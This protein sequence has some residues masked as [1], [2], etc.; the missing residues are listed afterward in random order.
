MTNTTDFPTG[1]S[2]LSLSLL[3]SNMCNIRWKNK[4]EE[5]LRRQFM[6]RA[7]LPASLSTK[8]RHII[9]RSHIE[10]LCLFNLI[11]YRLSNQFSDENVF[12]N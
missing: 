4:L 3:D 7:I 2:S 10:A 1:F 6:S 12:F 5:D 8:S 9:E 11:I